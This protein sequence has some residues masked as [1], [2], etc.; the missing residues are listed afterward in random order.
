MQPGNQNEGSR[1]SSDWEESDWTDLSEEEEN[2]S[3]EQNQISQTESRPKTETIE[4]SPWAPTPSESINELMAL[5]E[6]YRP[7]E[8]R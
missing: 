2:E 4:A 5:K 7:I 1:E 3:L 8:Y 6:N